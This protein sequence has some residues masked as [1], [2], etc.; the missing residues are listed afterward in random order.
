MKHVFIFLST[1]LISVFIIFLIFSFNIRRVCINTLS[2]YIVKNEITDKV[3]DEIK[4]SYPDLSED[5]ITDIEINI[6]N[7]SE[8]INITNKYFESIINESGNPNI[9]TNLFNLIGEFQ[10]ILEEN[11]IVI[12]NEKK[13]EMVQKLVDSK[14]IERVKEKT[15]K[16]AKE[17]QK[18]NFISIYN[19]I[20]SSTFRFLIVSIIVIL[21]LLIAFMKKTY[22]RWT[23]NLSVSFFL[24]GLLLTLIFPHVII[25]DLKNINL[26][27]IINSGYICFVICAL[28]V[29]IYIIGNKITR[30]N[31]RKYL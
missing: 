2:N 20:S 17:N 25:K 30:Y 24:D 19:K 31:D 21:V 23:Y 7:S 3:V 15:L 5:A 18:V 10:D 12:T 8:I 22:Y 11:E 27:S 29:I 4:T 28:L 9:K 26:T 6:K 13:Q 14:M 1:I 16:M